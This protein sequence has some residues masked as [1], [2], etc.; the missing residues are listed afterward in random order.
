MKLCS[1]CLL[2]VQCRY[3]GQI[4]PN[5]QAVKLAVSEPLIPVCPEQLGGQATPR[6]NAEIKGGDGNDVL[7]GRATV[8]EPDGRDITGQFVAG[9]HEVLKLAKLYG[10]TEAILK[11][12]SPSCGSGKIYDGTFSGKLTDGDGVTAAL[13]KQSGIKILSE[14]ELT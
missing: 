13:L 12:R 4:K 8:I 6:P 10:A 9:A 3:D 14:D 2:G 1:A 7:A 5:K 11:S